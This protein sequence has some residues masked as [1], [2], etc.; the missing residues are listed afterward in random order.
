M[1]KEKANSTQKVVLFC[2]NNP[3]L[4]NSFPKKS[5]RGFAGKKASLRVN[6]KLTIPKMCNFEKK[7]IGFVISNIDK[8]VFDRIQYQCSSPM[9]LKTGPVIDNLISR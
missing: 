9:M 8:S 5:R 2:T 1:Q 7:K 6:A 3:F 4:Y